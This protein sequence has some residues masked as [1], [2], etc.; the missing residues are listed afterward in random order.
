[1]MEAPDSRWDP[2]EL[3]RAAKLL[4]EFLEGEAN[5]QSELVEILDHHLVGGTD[6]ETSGR[7]FDA[8]SFY[9]DEELAGFLMGYL[10]YA[11]QDEELRDSVHALVSKPVGS[12]LR[13]ALAMYGAA[14]TEAAV[15]SGQDPHAW[16]DMSR[17]VFQDVISGEWR[18][19]IE[20][21]TYGG[22]SVVFNETPDTTLILA[23]AALDT[24]M[25]AIESAGVDILDRGGVAP[26]VERISSFLEATK[27]IREAAESEDAAE[28]RERNSSYV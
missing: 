23:H 22:E 1:M 7:L 27:P 4:D 16:R 8:L 26:F 6:A 28:N 12:Y 5:H 21:D 9:A 2:D 25:A 11:D 17:E 3:E 14:A 24:V 18:V 13:K 10:V 20:I 15:V 19:R